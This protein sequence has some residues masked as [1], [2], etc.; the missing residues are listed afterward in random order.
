MTMNCHRQS[1][2]LF[3]VHTDLELAMRL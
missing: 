2:S 3:V 1:F